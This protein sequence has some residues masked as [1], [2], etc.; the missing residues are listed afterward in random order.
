MPRVQQPFQTHF[1][2]FRLLRYHT[3]L[4][5]P[6]LIFPQIQ[7]QAPFPKILCEFSNHLPMLYIHLSTATTGLHQ[8]NLHLFHHQQYLIPRHNHIGTCPTRRSSRLL[9]RHLRPLRPAQPPIACRQFQLQQLS[10][11][12]AVCFLWIARFHAWRLHFPVNHHDI[13]GLNL[14]HL[15]QIVPVP[16]MRPVFPVQC[17]RNLIHQHCLTTRVQSIYPLHIPD[18]RPKIRKSS[19]KVLQSPAFPSE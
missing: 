18:M 15:V 10:F 5:R 9:H 6:R 14:L 13:D 12:P 2:F 1:R 17:Y 8:A 3:N 7:Y 11:R 16:D 19:K 4:H